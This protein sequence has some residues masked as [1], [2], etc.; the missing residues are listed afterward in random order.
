[1]IYNFEVKY[2]PGKRMAVADFGSRSPCL[3]EA[4]KDFILGN[5]ETGI[6]VKSLRV[7]Q[8]DVADPKLK[9]LAARSRRSRLANDDQLHRERGIQENLLE[10]NPELLQLKGDFVNLGLKT[11]S[12]RKLK[13]KNGSNVMIPSQARKCILKE[14][15][16]NQLGPDMMKNI[17]RGRFFWAKISEDVETTFLE[18]PGC[19]SEAASKCNTSRPDT[20]CASRVNQH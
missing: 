7:R 4:H 2:K 18:C 14:L 6:T 5:N 9:Q 8:L 1:M 19:Q 11:L 10:E 15:H 12:K 16:S 3:E 20:A 13:V 17:N